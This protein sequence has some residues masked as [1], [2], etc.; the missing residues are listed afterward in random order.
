MWKAYVRAQVKKEQRALWSCNAFIGRTRGLTLKMTLWLY[1]RVVIHK[2][3][4]VAVAWWDITGIVLARCEMEHLLRAACIMITGAMR[5][6]PIKVLEMPLDLPILETAM[7]SA[8]LK[9]AY[10]LLRT[11]PRKLGIGRN[12]IRAKADKVDSKFST[13]KDHITLRRNFGK[14]RITIPTREEWGRGLAQSTEKRVCQVH[15]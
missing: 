13:I 3:I 8:A 10:R 12:W 7:E 14:Y 5:T 11:D 15:R 2:I 6:T 1:K 4:Y 9:A